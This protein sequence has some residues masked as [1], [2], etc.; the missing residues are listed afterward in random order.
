ME[1]R[2]KTLRMYRHMLAIR[3]FEHKAGD[4][5][6]RDAVR[7]SIHLYTGQEAVAVGV[8]SALEPGDYVVSTHRGHGHCI[9]KG[10]RLREMMA[11]LLG[12]ATGYCKGRGGSMHIADFGSGILGANGIVGGGMGI[13]IG[14][15]LS[16]KYL[17]N[18]RLS[19]CFFGDG[20]ANQGIFH[21][22]LNL[23][24]VWKV[25]AI[26]VCENNLYALSTP[27]R[28]AFAIEHVV[29]R[30][31][32]YGMPGCRVD[33]NDV[34][35][36]YEAAREA[37]TRA[38]GGG[39]PTLIEAVTYRMDGHFRGDPCLYRSKQEVEEWAARD[40]ITR[41]RA[42][43]IESGVASAEELAA[44]EDEVRAEIEDAVRFA[45]ESPDPS[46]QDMLND[47]YA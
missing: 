40:P 44:I 7:G 10:G 1:S 28:D 43:L 15:A 38:R 42:K 21:E 16:A 5:F 29:D 36:V 4:L 13:A 37:C 17:K 9:A 26:F 33:G 6:T 30:A 25:P 20:A 11:E 46:P 47:I 12:K 31:A 35:A 34:L 22:A 39:G 19:V 24:A 27:F 14:A 45:L 32:G 3:Q 18:G 23:A 41:F 8:C 2:E